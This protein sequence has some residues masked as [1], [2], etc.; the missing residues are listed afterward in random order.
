MIA[1]IKNY[2]FYPRFHFNRFQFNL[3]AL[4]FLTVGFIT[5]SYFALKGVTSLFA[6]ANSSVAKDTDTDFNQG[7]LTSTTISGS[8]TSAV[9]KLL[10]I[11]GFSL[12]WA[13]RKKITFDNSAQ[14]ENLVNF[15]VLVKLN[16]SRIDYS[17][18]QDSGQDIRFTD[19]DG[20]TLL[21]Y[22][23]E[24]W[25]ETG[26]SFVWVKVPQIDASSN[27]DYIYMY[28]GNSSATDG[29]SATDVWDSN[30]VMI[31]HLKDLT[32]STT[33]DS[34]SNNNDGTKKAIDEPIETSGKIGKGQNFDGSNDYVKMAHSSSL[35]PN[36]ELTVSAWIY[37]NT[38]EA[39]CD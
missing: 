7:T 25:D 13:Y 8:G 19:S 15:P 39:D 9:V 17:K 6:T 27:T 38:Y 26:D 1:R 18:T 5:G 32:A 12:N 36:D 37:S 22:E 30:Y 14:V 35:L 16:S 4:F 29:Q 28:Y 23:I 2:L 24:K 11:S 3:V 20:T 34:T 31:Q 10:G 21:P 33:N